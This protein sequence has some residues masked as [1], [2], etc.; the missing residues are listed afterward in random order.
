MGDLKN[1]WSGGERLWKVFW[2]YNMVLGTFLSVTFDVVAEENLLLLGLL[3]GVM[4]IWAVWV[5][6]SLWRCAFNTDWRGWGYIVRALVLLSLVTVASTIAA[7][8]LGT[9]T[10]IA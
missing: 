5:T 2:L 6:V 1:A 9:G 10:E 3:S 4:I 8:F 7:V